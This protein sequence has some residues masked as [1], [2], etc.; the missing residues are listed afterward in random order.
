MDASRVAYPVQCCCDGGQGKP[1]CFCSVLHH[2]LSQSNT[3]DE[4]AVSNKSDFFFVLAQFVKLS[5]RRGDYLLDS[6]DQDKI[7]KINK[8]LE[9]TEL[10][11]RSSNMLS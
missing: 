6:L 5:I 4:T 9:R 10:D 7:N 2:F 8:C 1:A 11:L 3:L